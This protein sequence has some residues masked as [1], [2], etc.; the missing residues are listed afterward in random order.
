MRR[1][2]GNIRV[3]VEYC[4]RVEKIVDR[5]DEE[6]FLESYMIQSSC[7]FSVLQIG[8]AVKRLSLGFAEQHPEVSWNKIARFRDVLAH[9]YGNIDLPALWTISSK[10]IPELMKQCIAILEKGGPC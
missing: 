7:A 10:L 6:D 8:E 3:I 4:E 1:D 2:I 5:L 9:R